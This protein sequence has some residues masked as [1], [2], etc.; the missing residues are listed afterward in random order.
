MKLW[1]RPGQ[2]WIFCDLIRFPYNLHV[3]PC[4]PVLID[5]LYP[6]QFAE[7]MSH[8]VSFF[9]VTGINCS[10]LPM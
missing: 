9:A 6:W 5:S 10:V 8:T 2:F 4:L 3:D 7:S 1:A